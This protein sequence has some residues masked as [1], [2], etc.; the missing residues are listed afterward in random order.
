MANAVGQGGKK[1]GQEAAKQLLGGAIGSG[2]SATGSD[3]FTQNQNQAEA[4]LAAPESAQQ[5][6]EAVQALPGSTQT[7][8]NA[9]EQMGK[10]ASETGAPVGA[11][12]KGAGLRQIDQGQQLVNETHQ[13]YNDAVAG[14][15]RATQNA[16]TALNSAAEKAKIDP[17][18]YLNNMG[19]GGKLMTAIGMAL[20][21]IGS[22][23][24][25]QP[26][27][28][29]DA[30]QKNMDRAIQ[31]QAMEFKNL[32]EVSAQKQ[33]LIKTAQDKQQI[34]ANAYNAAVMS[35]ATGANVAID[36]TTFQINNLQALHMAQQLKL[37]NNIKLSES[38]DNHS[39]QF[40]TNLQ[41]GD[42]RRSTLMGDAAR[43]MAEKL[44][45]K[46]PLPPTQ[47]YSPSERV[48]RP[49]PGVPNT[50]AYEKENSF[51]DD[52]VEPAQPG[53]T[54][55][56]DDKDFYSAVQRHQDKQAAREKAIKEGSL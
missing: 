40:K 41:S 43:V 22:G 24:T 19:V 3:N 32:M 23:V 26:N 44:G 1:L 21:G 7:A 17:Q 47:G 42:V 56:Y 30:Y 52:E 36:G 11:A 15:I 49:T 53:M 31:A 12:V 2:Q 8:N 18:A 4:T 45:M 55:N 54:P 35:V 27:L 37:L 46:Q 6:V 48:G 10:I 9:L 29:M 34:A 39:S 38:T 28:A 5:G 25:G 20:S 13:D 33:G 16:E 50:P 14:A 51:S